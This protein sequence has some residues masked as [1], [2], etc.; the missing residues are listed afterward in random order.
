MGNICIVTIVKDDPEG[1]QRTMNSISNQR[2]VLLDWVIVDSS[3]EPIVF[4]SDLMRDQSINLI[5]TPAKGIDSA[6]NLGLSEVRTEWVQFLNAGD[7]FVDSETLAAVIK[8]LEG[9]NSEWAYGY[10]QFDGGFRKSEKSPQFDYENEQRKR[11]RRGKFPL[12]PSTIYRT[13]ALKEIGGFDE[14]YRVSADYVVALRL[15]LRSRPCELNFLTTLFS[16]GGTS[17]V[18]WFVAYS[19]GL[20]ARFS[21]FS[22]SGPRILLER[23]RSFLGNSIF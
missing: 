21:V 13:N 1:F 16:R 20:Q 19:E 3:T 11:F 7:T 17:N 9:C 14:N 5:V 10:L 22:L 2:D 8:Q 23:V 12:Q 6:M 4:Q 18:K 15:S